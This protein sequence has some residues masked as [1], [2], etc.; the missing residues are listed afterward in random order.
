M[1]ASVVL[2]NHLSASRNNRFDAQIS[3]TDKLLFCLGACRLS[4]KNSERA[5]LKSVTEIR[6]PK[7]LNR[8]KNQLKKTARTK[9]EKPTAS[10][11]KRRDTRVCISMNQS[12]GRGNTQ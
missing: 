7:I 11:Y 10:E 2:I 12:V 3:Q 4:A 9:K 5:S 1:I 8:K 6:H